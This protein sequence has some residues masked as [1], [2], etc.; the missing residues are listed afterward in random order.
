MNF[1]CKYFLKT[2]LDIGLRRFLGRTI[3]EIRKSIDNFFPNYL[4]L[5]LADANSP[6]PNLKKTLNNLKLNSRNYWSSKKENKEF[7]FTFLNV[8]K[9]FSL[10]INW[11]DKNSSHLWRFNLHYFEWAREYL[12]KRLENGI[13]PEDSKNLKIII[14]DWIQNNNLGEGDGWHSYTISLRIRNWIYIIRT[15]PEFQKKKYIDSLWLQICWLYSHKEYFLGGNHWLENLISLIIGSLQF[16]GKKAN[17]IFN[18]S[19]KELEIQL[20]KQILGDGGHEE[21]S[22]SYH[23]LILERLIELGLIIENILGLDLNG[24]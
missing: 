2:I 10:P 21:R 18:Y 4:I 9:K 24:L 6:T 3:Y 11:N 22:A 7:S 15:C 17:I 13:W 20:N 5:I 16:E 1:N 19:L 8:T 14:D 12:E 23:L